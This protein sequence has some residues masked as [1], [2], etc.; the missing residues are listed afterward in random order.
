MTKE[1]QVPGDFNWEHYLDHYPDLRQNGVDTKEKAERHWINFGNKEGRK[2]LSPNLIF[3]R[4]AAVFM[5]G[6]FKNRG[7]IGVEIGV[8][9]GEHACSLLKELS[10]RTLY[11]IDP[12]EPFDEMSMTEDIKKT[13]VKKLNK[14]RGRV[15][16]IFK[17]SET[18]V[19]DIQEKV[20]FV[21]ID[22]RHAYESVKKDINLYWPLIK[23]GGVLC[24]HDINIYGVAR[25]VVEFCKAKGL[26]FR[27]SD[28]DWWIVK[29]ET[30]I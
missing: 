22:G 5:K 28:I 26:I 4:A 14:F 3:P 9:K 21:Y 23:E 27:G 24:G 20:D 30:S 13:A 16:F 7:L 8:W 11:A 17:H 15:K 18:A 25:A 12:Y 1:K 19:H 2:Y 10:L 29:A 6:H